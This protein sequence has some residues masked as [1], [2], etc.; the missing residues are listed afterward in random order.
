[1]FFQNANNSVRVPDEFMRAV[2]DDSNWQT[3]FVKS[4]ES[5]GEYRARDLMRMIAEAAHA[6]GDPGMQFDSTINNWHTCPA[7][8]RINASNPCS[9]YMHLDN[10]AC[11]L[12]SLNLL[13]FIDE[14]GEFDVR[15]FP[16]RGRRDD[17]RAGHPGRQLVVSDRGDRAQRALPTA[18]WA[19]ATRTWARC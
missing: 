4:G 19:W 3:H 1:M 17:H 12:A 10:S 11:N 2:L 13:K 18:S 15:A 16:P 14:R 7:S 6:C 5:A 8:G 9:E